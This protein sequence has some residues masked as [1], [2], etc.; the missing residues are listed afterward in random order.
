MLRLCGE[1]EDKLAQELIQFE[2]QVE[3]DVIEPL[4]VLAEVGMSGCPRCGLSCPPCAALF[5][6]P[7]GRGVSA[8][9]AETRF[10]ARLLFGGFFS[11]CCQLSGFFFFLISPNALLSPPLLC[12]AKCH[13]LHSGFI[14]P[15][16]Y[17][18][19]TGRGEPGQ[20]E[21]WGFQA[22]QSPWHTLSVH[23]ELCCCAGTCWQPFSAFSRPSWRRRPY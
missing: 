16:L 23:D 7:E 5:C 19:D 17:G 14:F 21:L 2:L 15:Q 22:L 9:V 3:R 12:L 11:S 13:G 18:S 8:C 1:A 10:Q 6:F 20:A 4:F